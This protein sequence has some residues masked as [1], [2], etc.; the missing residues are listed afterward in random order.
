ML[1]VIVPKPMKRMFWYFGSISLQKY[2]SNSSTLGASML[3]S[4]ILT[5]CFLLLMYAAMLAS[6]SGGKFELT[7]FQTFCCEYSVGGQMSRQSRFFIV[8]LLCST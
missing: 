5:V 3:Q 1:Q 6:P 2:V 8:F 4:I 7:S